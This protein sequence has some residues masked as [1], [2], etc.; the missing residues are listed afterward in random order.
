MSRRVLLWGGL[1]VIAALFAG[2]LYLFALSWRPSTDI[3]DVQ[4]IDVS[5]ANGAIDWNAAKAAGAS[6]G[7]IAATDGGTRDERFEE[8]WRAAAAAD[9]RRGA[10]HVWSLCQ[11]AADQANNFNTVVPK[12]DDSLPPALS[13]DFAAGC[14]ARPMRDAVLGEIRRFV[15]MVEAHT[16]RPVILLASRAFEAQYRVTEAIDR[17]I[18]SAGNFLSPDYAER[19]WRMWRASDMR[20]IDGINGPVNWDVV[21]K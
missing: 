5:A 3:Y 15:T 13:M 19:P 10:V 4:G 8:N 1:S 21:A 18:W 16:D 6:F 20:R 12:T 11:P 9:V 2:A 14:D 7:Y 17:P